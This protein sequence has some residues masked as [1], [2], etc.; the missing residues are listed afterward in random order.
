MKSIL[1]FILIVTGLSLSAQFTVNEKRKIAER[2][3]YA[4][5]CDSLLQQKITI[6]KIQDEQIKVLIN[7]ETNLNSQ[8][9]EKDLY[10]KYNENMVEQLTVDLKGCEYTKKRLKKQRNFYLKTSLFF[11]VCTLTGVYFLFIKH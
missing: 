2:I 8:L 6:I 5:F 1:T 7:K 10:I 9:T 11:G 4:N 3:T